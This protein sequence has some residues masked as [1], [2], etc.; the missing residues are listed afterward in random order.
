MVVWIQIFVP[1]QI[2]V[3][4]GYTDFFGFSACLVQNS[5]IRSC[6]L[7]SA[8]IAATFSVSILLACPVGRHG[9][10]TVFQASS[11]HRILT[12]RENQV[13]TVADQIGS[14][15][16]QGAHGFR[17][18]PV[19]T[20]HHPYLAYPY[21]KEIKPKVAGLKP[22]FFFVKQMNLPVL[23]QITSGRYNHCCI[24]KIFILPFDQTGDDVNFAFQRS[25]T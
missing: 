22:E 9:E 19:K 14:V 18:E 3:Y 20:D 13:C 15:E 17:E 10:N 8:C 5:C 1:S 7:A 21:I 4:F 12:E 25:R 11:L 6:Y 24:E 23:S 2:N 16:C